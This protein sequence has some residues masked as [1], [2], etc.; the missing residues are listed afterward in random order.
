MN[1]KIFSLLLAI[2]LIA[3]IMLAG[4]GNNGTTIPETDMNGTATENQ[5]ANGSNNGQANSN[6]KYI[7]NGKFNYSDVIA[8][9]FK[10]ANG[11]GE[12]LFGHNGPAVNAVCK[13]IKEIYPDLAAGT[14]KNIIS[15]MINV[16]NVEWANKNERGMQNGDVLTI[17]A[18]IIQKKVD[19]WR[20]NMG[21]IELIIETEYTVTV[22][23]LKDK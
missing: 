10:G 21:G 11:E 8:F 9:H 1:K 6:G 5:D 23:G 17:E 20:E 19:M 16:E 15:P 7:K 22:E 12:L 18:S 3:C 2:C 14:I 13:E 4:C